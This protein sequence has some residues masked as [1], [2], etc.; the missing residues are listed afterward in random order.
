LIASRAAGLLVAADP[1]FDSRREQLVALASYHAIPAI[2]QW[3]EFALAGGLMTYGSSI[4]DL[5]RQAGVYAGRVLKGERPS[6]LPVVQPTKFEL[7]INLKTAKALGLDV[8]P[9]LLS[10]ADEVIE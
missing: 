3:R 7:I 2:Y 4:T 6:D 9:T 1:F 10:L 5:Y 8:P